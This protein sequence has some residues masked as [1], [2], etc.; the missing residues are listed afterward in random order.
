MVKEEI[1]VGVMEFFATG[2]MPEGVNDTSIVLIPKVQFP[3]ELKDFRPISLCNVIYKIISKC[4]VNWLC[5]I[6]SR[7]TSVFIPGRLITYNSII[8]FECM[9]YIQSV[10]AGSP[11]CCAYK[12]DLSKAYDRVDCFFFFWRRPLANG[13]SHSSGSRGSWHVFLRLNI[14]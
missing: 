3:K 6:L 4:M 12:L 5:P 2:V 1:I 13:V 11:A 8:T 7:K 10:G 14:L 9:D